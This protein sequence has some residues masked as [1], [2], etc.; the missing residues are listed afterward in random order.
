MLVAV[1][2]FPG[3]HGRKT[4][5]LCNELISVFFN[6]EHTKTQSSGAN[7]GRHCDWKNRDD[8]QAWSTSQSV[9][10]QDSRRKYIL[11]AHSRRG[12]AVKETLQ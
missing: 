5:E 11:R 1:Q 12:F 4:G 6:D 3:S 2:I 8:R 9:V 7:Q 10:F